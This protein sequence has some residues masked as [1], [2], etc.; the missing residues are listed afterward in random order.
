MIGENAMML[1]KRADIVI[2]YIQAPENSLFPD[3]SP[4]FDFAEKTIIYF[5]VF[6]IVYTP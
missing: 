6:Q 1:S 2:Y 4:Q 3:F 5:K